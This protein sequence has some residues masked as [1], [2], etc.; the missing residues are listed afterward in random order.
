MEG[1]P[2]GFGGEGEVSEAGAEDGRGERILLLV[3]GPRAVLRE[4]RT[5]LGKRLHHLLQQLQKQERGIVWTP[6]S[7]SSVAVRAQVLW[8]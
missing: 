2:E 6:V 4:S 5:P 7:L 8:V 3:L 1:E